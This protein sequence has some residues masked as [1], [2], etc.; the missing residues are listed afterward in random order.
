[1]ENTDNTFKLK[2]G[3]QFIIVP[4]QPNAI[5]KDSPDELVHLYL[6][7]EGVGVDVERRKAQ[8]ETLPEKKSKKRAAKKATPKPIEK[9]VGKK[10][11]EEKGTSEK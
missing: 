3:V 6:S 2:E 10:A 1:M 5:T 8:F 9:V 7:Q 4:G 11:K